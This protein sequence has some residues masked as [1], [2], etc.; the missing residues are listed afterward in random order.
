MS[1]D[2]VNDSA[3]YLLKINLLLSYITSAHTYAVSED[4]TVLQPHAHALEGSGDACRL[5][6][7]RCESCVH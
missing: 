7:T 3:T 5:H 6:E 4:I 2:V 1:Y